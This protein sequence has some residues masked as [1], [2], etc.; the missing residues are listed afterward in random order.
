MEEQDGQMKELLMTLEPEMLLATFIASREK[1]VPLMNEDA[2]FRKIMLEQILRLELPKD[3]TDE[4]YILFKAD[5]TYLCL[6]DKHIY[7]KF[8]NRTLTTPMLNTTM[9][10]RIRRETKRINTDR[11]FS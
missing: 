11:S 1:I 3:V 7:Q 4:L 5:I 10:S 8:K 6:E 2:H 9:Y